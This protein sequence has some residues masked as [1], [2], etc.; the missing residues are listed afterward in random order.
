MDSI[1]EYLKEWIKLGYT[2]EQSKELVRLS[3]LGCTGDIEAHVVDKILY[4]TVKNMKSRK[5]DK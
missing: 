1:Q 4:E 3:V 5:G 2:E